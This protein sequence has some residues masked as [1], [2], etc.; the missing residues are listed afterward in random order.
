[1][2][3]FVYL[4]F[5]TGTFLFSQESI[6][7]LG[8]LSNEISETSGLIFHNGK[9]I[10]HNDSGNTPQLFEIDT[11][12]YQITR[13][14]TLSNVANI[15]WEDIAQDSEYIYIGDFGN[16]LGTRTDLSLSLIH[17]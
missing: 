12:S 1:M 4:I 8:V 6:E 14:V 9:L 13:T 2:R 16:N 17:I 10:T 11:V 5:L 7:V 3:S 15:D